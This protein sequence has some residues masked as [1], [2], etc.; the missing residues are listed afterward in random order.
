MPQMDEL[1]ERLQVSKE[2]LMDAVADT[3]YELVPAEGPAGVAGMEE[4]M[5]EEDMAEEEGGMRSLEDVLSGIEGEEE[6]VAEEEVKEEEEMMDPAPAGMEGGGVKG[7]SISVMRG[8]AAKNA[9]E[10]HKKKDEDE[11]S[12]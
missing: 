3:G 9:F 12:A 10:K 8:N 4:D 11:E 1:A 6:G 7:V 5:A 2:E